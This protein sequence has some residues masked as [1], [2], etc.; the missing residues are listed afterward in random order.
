M[1]RESAFVVSL[2]LGLMLTLYLGFFQ[3]SESGVMI[4][5]AGQVSEWNFG[6]PIPYITERSYL[7]NVNGGIVRSQYFS[8]PALLT[9][10]LVWSSIILGCLRVAEFLSAMK[11]EKRKL[12]SQIEQKSERK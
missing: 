1:R 8:S 3:V 10:W 4:G 12:I 2:F 5:T 6:F 11:L 7:L 9:D